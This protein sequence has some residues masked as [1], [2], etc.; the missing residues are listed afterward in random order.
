MTPFYLTYGRR[1][2]MSDDEENSR[3][4]IMIKRIEDIIEELPIQRNQV[5]K[6]P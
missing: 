4:I 2:L 1:I 3:Q 5:K 6:I